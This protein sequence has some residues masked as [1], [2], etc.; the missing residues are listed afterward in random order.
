MKRI[1]TVGACA[2]V[3]SLLLSGDASSCG[4]RATGYAATNYSY[5]AAYGGYGAAYGGTVYG[6]NAPS[7]GYATAP[8]NAPVGSGYG[9][10]GYDYGRPGYN[11]GGLGGPWSGLGVRPGVGVGGFGL[12]R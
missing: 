3:A 8:A 1:L 12:R 5:G 10:G 7:Y 6:G 4:R 9:Y 11:P 2:I